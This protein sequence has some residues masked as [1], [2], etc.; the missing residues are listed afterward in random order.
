MLLMIFDVLDIFRMVV[1]LDSLE[2]K[3]NL[4]QVQYDD[5]AEWPRGRTMVSCQIFPQ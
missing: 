3:I 2:H 1:S 4:K 5:V